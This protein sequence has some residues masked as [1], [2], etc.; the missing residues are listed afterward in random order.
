MGS[1]DILIRK[2]KAEYVCDICGHKIHKDE[3]YLDKVYLNGKYT[4]HVRYHDECPRKSVVEKAAWA[5]IKHNFQAPVI[6][7]NQKY[8]FVGLLS[9]KLIL[10]FNEIYSYI[11]IEEFNKMEIIK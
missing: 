3:E 11:P 4:R 8:W 9:N 5:L 1:S 7:E 10:I 6:Y 2:A